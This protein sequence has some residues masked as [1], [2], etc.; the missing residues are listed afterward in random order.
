M[1]DTIFY[2]S[3]PDGTSLQMQ[4]DQ[5]DRSILSNKYIDELN[6]NGASIPITGRQQASSSRFVTA[7]VPN[8]GDR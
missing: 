4:A 6:S 5:V 8:G 3:V 2:D 1:V 7:V